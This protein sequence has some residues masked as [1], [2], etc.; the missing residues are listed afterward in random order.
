MKKVALFCV[1]VILISMFTVY[2]SAE[3]SITYIIDTPG[4][5]NVRDSKKGGNITEVIRSGEPVEV[6]DS[7]DK[8]WL[9]IRRKDGSIGYIIKGENGKT[10]AHPAHAE[11]LEAL[12]NKKPVRIY[13]DNTDAYLLAV[14]TKDATVYKKANEKKLGVIEAG[15]IVYVRQTGRYWYKIIWANSEVAYVQT[16]CLELIGP[17]IPGDEKVYYLTGGEN[18]DSLAVV[19]TEPNAKAERLVSLKMSS[20]VRVIEDVDGKWVKVRYD[21]EGNEGYMYK[22]WLKESKKF[23]NE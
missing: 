20:F 18:P 7:S 9:Q 22:K 11:E 3:S 10:Y 14:A 16:E 13:V 4:G 5:V 12:Q 1:F 17:N 6:I 8:Y 2:A 23:S 21:A 15:E 19:R